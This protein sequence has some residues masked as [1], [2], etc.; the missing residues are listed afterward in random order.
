MK[1]VIVLNASI[2]SRLWIGNRPP[3][4]MRFRLFIT[5]GVGY[6]E[7]MVHASPRA[8]AKVEL[9]TPLAP[10]KLAPSI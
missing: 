6:F 4:K 2:E 3:P 8:P 10:K 5:V 7:K 9:V 1:S